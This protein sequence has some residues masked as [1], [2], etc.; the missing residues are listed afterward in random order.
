MT[1]N[2][3]EIG[4]VIDVQ[5]DFM[6]PAEEGGRLYVRDL[7][8]RPDGGAI[9]KMPAIVSGVRWMQE[10]C[11]VV[12]YT[13]DWHGP[14]DEEIDAVSPDASKGTFP[15]HCMG[16]SADAA[17]RE[18]AAII[19]EVAPENPVV[20]ASDASAEQAREVA[21]IAVAER[22]PVFVQKVRFGVFEGNPA[23]DALLAALQQEL[24]AELRFHVLGVATD[25]CVT[26]A[27]DGLT[28]PERGYAVRAYTDAMHGLGI[29][30]EE[31]THRRWAEAGVELATV[32][33]IADVAIVAQ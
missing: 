15:P 19:R 18:G 25:V 24:G 17:E 7:F 30:P 12:L 14:E 5:N 1:R 13:G 11:A 6:R 2:V 31:E 27:I 23:M 22:R 9:T 4:L 16:R 20:L 8:C 3:A 28:A 21:R 26:Q 32:A 29:E 10:N 33:C